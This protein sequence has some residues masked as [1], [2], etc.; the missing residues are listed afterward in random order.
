[1]Q[2]SHLRVIFPLGFDYRHMIKT[3][4]EETEGC[5]MGAVLHKNEYWGDDVLTPSFAFGM[6]VH[7]GVEMPEDTDIFGKPEPVPARGIMRGEYYRW[8][9]MTL[10]PER[11]SGGWGWLVFILRYDMQEGPET[12]PGDWAKA[13]TEGQAPAFYYR[14][15]QHAE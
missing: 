6:D 13:Y 3:F 7:V 2:V 14:G 10:A 11:G 9:S 8:D 12:W 1:M 4:W 15:V 5:L